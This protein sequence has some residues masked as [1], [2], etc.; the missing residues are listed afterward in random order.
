MPDSKNLKG[1]P[2]YDYLTGQNRCSHLCGPHLNRCDLDTNEQG[3]C[4]KGDCRCEK[5]PTDP[6]TTNTDPQTPTFD[7]Q[8]AIEATS[9][10]LP[11]CS[12]CQS[13]EV[14]AV[15]RTDIRYAVIKCIDCLHQRQLTEAE[16]LTEWPGVPECEHEETDLATNKC[17]RCF[18]EAPECDE[19]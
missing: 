4:H 8:K 1:E 7:I 19:K 6:R 14:L 15:R 5:C 3:G 10:T 12:N 13:N 11:A 17:I 18:K 9:T 16:Y 2:F